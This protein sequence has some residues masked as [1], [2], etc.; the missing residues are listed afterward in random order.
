MRPDYPDVSRSYLAKYVPLTA[1][2]ILDVGCN[3]G[4][5]GA[6]LKEQR[7]VEVWGVEPAREAANIAS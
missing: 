3:Q 4:G 7:Q 1:R 6:L 5:F 2:R